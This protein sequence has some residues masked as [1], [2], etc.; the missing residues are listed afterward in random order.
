M[1]HLRTLFP[2]GQYLEGLELLDLHMTVLDLLHVN[3]DGILQKPGTCFQINSQDIWGKTPLYWAA[4][5][6]DRPKMKALMLAGAD[7]SLADR[8][9]ETPL[10]AAVSSNSVECIRFLLSEKANV[11]ATNIHGEQPIHYASQKSV[12]LV[13]LLVQAGASME[14]HAASICL[15]W[16]A[17][18]NCCEVIQ[19]LLDLGV[20]RNVPDW[21]GNTPVF[22]A[23]ICHAYEALEL[24]LR[25][26]VNLCHQNKAGSTVL[27]CVASCGVKRTVEIMLNARLKD[28]DPFVQDLRGRGPREIFKA[29]INPPKDMERVFEDLMT[30]VEN[31]RWTDGTF[32][33]AED[34]FDALDEVPPT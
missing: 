15:D 5:R 11:H 31:D 1:Q 9:G 25:E 20:D 23:I 33:D 13:K 27:H 6:S 16:A 8:N 26:G 14:G 3:F 10:F 17:M 32:S 29:R 30:R 24:L 7:L 28:I 22:A 34:F 4:W 2:E 19:Y 18:G 21:A 12:V